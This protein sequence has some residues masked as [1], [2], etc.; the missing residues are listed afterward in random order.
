MIP[1]QSSDPQEEK[2]ETF[3]S[4]PH[5]DLPGDSLPGGSLLPIGCVGA[6]LL[7]GGAKEPSIAV[8]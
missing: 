7:I 4:P 5:S 1:S 3:L 6:T 8:L 2:G